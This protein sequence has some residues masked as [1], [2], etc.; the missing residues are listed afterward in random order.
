MYLVKKGEL[1]N[2]PYRLSIQKDVELRYYDA[3]NNELQ[4]SIKGVRSAY[5]NESY[6]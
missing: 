2:S 6:N 4:L 5:S 1:G 3:S